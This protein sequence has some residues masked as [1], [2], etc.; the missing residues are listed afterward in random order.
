MN[1]VF[2]L[3][4]VLAEAARPTRGRPKRARTRASLLAATAAEMERV[5]YE[6]LTVDYI[7]EAAG[8]ARGT[9]YL[10]FTNKNEAA[11][12]VLQ[13]Y[14]DTLRRSRPRL[15]AEMT[16]FQA[17]LRTNRYY[18]ATYALN[19]ALLAG[20][21]ALL[22][23]LPDLVRER[24]SLNHQWS[25]M[26]LRDFEK[27]CGGGSEAA[28]R[29]LKLMLVRTVVAMVDEFLR[30]LYVYRSPHLVQNAGD[31]DQVAE[32]ISFVWYRTLYGENPPEDE[33][34]TTASLAGFRLAPPLG[35]EYV[36]N[37]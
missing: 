26:V 29:S 24:D 32:L 6:S 36:L 11:V 4:T 8:L 30:E 18:V 13:E 12:E 21:E 5:G 17:I 28:P 3:S 27:R 34:T 7:V 19:A 2:R 14:T 25:I 22:R 9:F 15:A 35:L 23:E 37:C 20:Q 10:Y 31:H 16:P 1:G 33:L